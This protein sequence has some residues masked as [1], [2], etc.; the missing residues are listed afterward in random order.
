[1]G[2]FFERRTLNPSFTGTYST[3]SHIHCPA[4]LTTL[5]DHLQIGPSSG[6]RESTTTDALMN[7][8][9]IQKREGEN[10]RLCLRPDHF[11]EV[12]ASNSS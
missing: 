12:Y 7:E 10:K 4:L 11:G 3:P 2:E 8:K 5:R 9:I 1:M 6:I